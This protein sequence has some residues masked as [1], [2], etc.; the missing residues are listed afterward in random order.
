MSAQG[1]KETA[2]E[3]PSP[4]AHTASELHHLICR[5]ESLTHSVLSG[6]TIRW[7]PLAAT[8]SLPPPC[9]TTSSGY[10]RSGY[11]NSALYASPLQVRPDLACFGARLPLQSVWSGS[12]NRP[13][14]GMFSRSGSPVLYLVEYSTL[15]SDIF[16]NT[17]SDRCGRSGYQNTQLRIHLQPH[18][19]FRFRM[20]PLPPPSPSSVVPIPDVFIFFFLFLSVSCK[21]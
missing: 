16:E 14:T 21:S 20:P 6:G 2:G 10:G 3:A 17:T 1:E 13:F 11:T 12:A 9:L 19:R 18:R 7:P 15:R 5:R 4:C 8:A